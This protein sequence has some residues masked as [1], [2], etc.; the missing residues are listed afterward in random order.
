MRV[1]FAAGGT[2]GHLEPALNTADALVRM[3]PATS[4]SFIGGSRG[5]EAQLVPQRG[6]S[7]IQTGADP[8]PRRFNRAA[9]G[10]P[11][12]TVASV[13]AASAHLRAVRADVVVGFGGYAAV[14]G[15]LAA[16]RTKNSLDH[17]RGEFPSRIRE[18]SRRP[19]YVT[20]WRRARRCFHSR[21]AHGPPA[22]AR[23]SPFG[24]PCS[25]RSGPRSLGT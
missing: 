13:R 18:P 10:F 7:L 20:H 14:P 16:W 24:S 3:W 22:S 9:L 4:I 19:S 25:S 5:L 8:F 12:H 15:Y 23:G 1:V 11:V 17:P 6:Y 21:P 2:A